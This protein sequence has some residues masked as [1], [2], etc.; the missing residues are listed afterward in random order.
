MVEVAL[1]VTTAHGGEDI[2]LFLC[3]HTFGKDFD[4]Q[5]LRQSDDEADDLKLAFV[6]HAGDKETPVKF[7]KI[8]RHFG[9]HG[10][11]RL[12]GAEIIHFDKESIFS[13]CIKD[14]CDIIRVIDVGTFYDLQM[15]Q[16][17]R[18]IIL[19]QKLVKN[20]TEIF[21]VQIASGDIDRDS[22][23]AETKISTLFQDPASG[24]SLTQA[25]MQFWARSRSSISLGCFSAGIV[26]VTALRI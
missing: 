15:E 11:R 12:S 10:K 23:A 14:I 24:W 18:K 6:I 21:F 9:D 7:Q 4:V 22:K 3:F 2:C 1:G 13:K 26:A 5:T 25:R 20:L 8:D 19:L 16:I 17:S